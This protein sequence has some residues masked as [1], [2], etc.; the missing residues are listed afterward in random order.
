M[1]VNL[2]SW[3]ALWLKHRSDRRPGNSIDVMIRIKSTSAGS[4]GGSPAKVDSVPV[5]AVLGAG[6]F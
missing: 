4:I 2:Q 1:K 6:R 3:D 5:V